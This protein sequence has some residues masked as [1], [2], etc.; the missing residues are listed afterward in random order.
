MNSALELGFLKIAKS[1]TASQDLSFHYELDCSF[2]TDVLC[3]EIS[4][5]SIKSNVSNRYRNFILV[6]KLPCLILKKLQP[7]HWQIL[8]DNDCSI[9]FTQEG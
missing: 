5:F 2:V 1:T 4:F 6:Q 3:H 7:P 9:D 8:V